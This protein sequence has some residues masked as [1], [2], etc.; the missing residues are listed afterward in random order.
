MESLMVAVTTEAEGM[1]TVAVLN[2]ASLRPL[3]P[4]AMQVIRRTMLREARWQGRQQARSVA[5]ASPVAPQVPEPIVA[6]PRLTKLTKM[7]GCSSA[8]SEV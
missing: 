6:A 2:L 7:M 1:A 4:S 5:A 8:V 3:T